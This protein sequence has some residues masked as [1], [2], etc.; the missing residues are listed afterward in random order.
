MVQ[1]LNGSQ[2]C[3]Y[4]S[5]NSYDVSIAFKADLM[6]ARDANKAPP[7]ACSAIPLGAR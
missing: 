2:T 3:A 6:I 4:G 7:E 1:V 5:F